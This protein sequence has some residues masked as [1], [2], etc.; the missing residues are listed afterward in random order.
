MLPCFSIFLTLRYEVDMA[1]FGQKQTSPK[2]T[3]A[4]L[5]VG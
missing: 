3:Q 5:K 2:V 4:G 1:E